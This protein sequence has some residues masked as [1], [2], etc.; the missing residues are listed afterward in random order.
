ML[1]PRNRK[2][3]LESSTTQACVPKRRRETD[4][5]PPHWP[6]TIRRRQGSWFRTA[7]VRQA[8]SGGRQAGA[9]AGTAVSTC[10]IGVGWAMSC[11]AAR[12]G[13]RA[14]FSSRRSTLRGRGDRPKGG[15]SPCASATL[16]LPADPSS[17]RSKGAARSRAPN[18]QYQSFLC[19]SDFRDP[20]WART[21]IY[22]A[23]AGEP[24]EA[25]PAMGSVSSAGQWRGRP[26]TDPLFTRRRFRESAG[27]CRW[28]RGRACW[29]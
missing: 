19:H 7:G 20:S 23:G 26:P 24:P 4:G 1:R 21:A 3:H 6:T 5:A 11:V 15:S 25:D 22:D 17:E 14:G 13:A 28:S 18:R 2:R 27:A 8:R 10:G 9:G 12:C 16:V 29:R